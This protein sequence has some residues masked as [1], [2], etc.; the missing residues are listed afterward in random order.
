LLLLSWA[1]VCCCC[2]C[3]VVATAV[4]ANAAVVV[5]LLL[6]C[7]VVVGIVDCCCL[8]F[9]F[10]A[11]VLLSSPSL[12]WTYLAIEI[13]RKIFFL[14]AVPKKTTDLQQKEQLN[15]GKT[16]YTITKHSNNNYYKF[17]V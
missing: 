5:V 9:L 14:P 11:V 16:D 10:V 3:V 6:C 2:C 15:K 7:C 4:S 13:L 8:F 12:S 17:S 1:R